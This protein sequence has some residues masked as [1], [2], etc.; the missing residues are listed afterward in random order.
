MLKSGQISPPSSE[1]GVAGARL[2]NACATYGAR[3][4]KPSEIKLAKF[5]TPTNLLF[6]FSNTPKKIISPQF[7]SG[8]SRHQRDAFWHSF[9]V[10]RAH[11]KKMATYTSEHICDKINMWVTNSVVVQKIYVEL[12]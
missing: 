12:F 8:I 10:G 6:L 3:L 11:R 7:F 5:S 1:F 4:L 9:R 2:P